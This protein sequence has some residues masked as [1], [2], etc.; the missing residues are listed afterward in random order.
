MPWETSEQ[1]AEVW[2]EQGDKLLFLGAQGGEKVAFVWARTW[3]S[4]GDVSRNPIPGRRG[5]LVRRPAGKNVPGGVVWAAGHGARG[6]RQ[7]PGCGVSLEGLRIFTAGFPGCLVN[8]GS[9]LSVQTKIIYPGFEPWPSSCWGLLKSV[10]WMLVVK[11][12]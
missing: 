5:S 8:S 9:G 3:R 2:L 12:F 10:S 11:I 1:T 4:H 7:W 6:A